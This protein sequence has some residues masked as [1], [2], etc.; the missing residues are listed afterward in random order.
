ML[1]SVRYGSRKQKRALYRMC[2]LLYWNNDEWLTI[3]YSFGARG[4][5]HVSREDLDGACNIGSGPAAASVGLC[6]LDLRHIR[7]F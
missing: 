3:V 5:S 4:L 2:S 6:R 7:D 1:A